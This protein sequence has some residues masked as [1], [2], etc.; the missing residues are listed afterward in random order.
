MVKLIVESQVKFILLLFMSCINMYSYELVYDVKYKRNW[1]NF[2]HSKI[3]DFIMDC[4]RHY[5]RLDFFSIVL[6]F[7]KI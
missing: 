7:L 5:H 3:K 4:I 1:L 2:K 6:F